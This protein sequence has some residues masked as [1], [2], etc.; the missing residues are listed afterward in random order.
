V[1]VTKF[2]LNLTAKVK[3]SLKLIWPNNYSFHLQN[4]Q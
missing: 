2:V 3:T 4:V 1:E